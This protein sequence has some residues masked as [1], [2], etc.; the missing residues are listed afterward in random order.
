MIIPTLMAMH[1]EMAA[2]APSHIQKASVNYTIACKVEEAP[3]VKIAVTTD[4]IVYD[5]SHGTQELSALKT[6]TKSPFPPGTDS[7][8]GGLRQDHPTIHTRMQ[9]DIIW[10]QKGNM[11]C[12]RYKTI[13]I[14]IHLQPQIFLAKEFDN[15]TCR[16]AVLTHERRHVQVDRE[17]MNKYAGVIG[18]SVQ[19]IV[20]R[21][22]ALGPFNMDNV[23][24]VKKQSSGYITRTM[25]QIENAMGT[26]MRAR[27]QQVD[28]L[29]EYKRVGSFCQNVHV[30]R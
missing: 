2:Q 7:A 15:G 25:D 17:V 16:D 6:D 9:W 27:Q 18:R 20:N 21:V 24:A 26:E 4:D 8:T 19:D 10:E 12:M 11:G 14:E 23:E 22:G 28:S 29:E 13:D 3:H 1:L 30:K 5:Y